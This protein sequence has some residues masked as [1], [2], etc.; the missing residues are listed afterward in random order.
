M[1]EAFSLLCKGFVYIL[2]FLHAARLIIQNTPAQWEGHWVWWV[3]RCV[4]TVYCNYVGS[5]V[6]QTKLCGFCCHKLEF[7]PAY[8]YMCKVSLCGFSHTLTNMLASSSTAAS[9]LEVRS[10]SSVCLLPS[11]LSTMD[12]IVIFRYAVFLCALEAPRGIL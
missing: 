8:L 4:C 2:G 11:T 10:P 1:T 5:N 12:S 6:H 3:C 7:L 9:S